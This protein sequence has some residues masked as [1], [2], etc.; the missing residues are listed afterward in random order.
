MSE[1]KY[2]TVARAVTIEQAVSDGL[3]ELGLREHEVNIEVL[4]VPSKGF[5]GLFSQK[6]EVRLT[7][8]DYIMEEEKRAAKRQAEE[9]KEAKKAKERQ[10]QAE[11]VDKVAKRDEKKAKPSREDQPKQKAQTKAPAKEEVGQGKKQVEDKGKKVEKKALTSEREE[12]VSNEGR[13]KRQEGQEEARPGKVV[14]PEDLKIA[15]DQ[16]QKFL[17]Q[18]FAAMDLEIEVQVEEKEGQTFLVLVGDNLGV[19]IGKRGQ[20]LDSLQY[21]LNIAV[22]NYTQ[23]HV[24]LMLD[25]EDYR[26]RRQKT[27]EELADRLA[28][29][30]KKYRKEVSLE[31]MSAYE[32]KVIHAHLQNHT[33]IV[34][35]SYGSEP[36][37]RLVISPKGRNRK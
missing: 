18:V 22:N 26:I 33:G 23:D 15:I 24:R 2:T 29:K 3:A 21:L 9:A 11:K 12:K 35:K 30:A 27:L 28:N 25:A 32:R 20:T 4:T 14:S 16:G 36:Y 19:L 8:L 7:S 10:A 34:T 5:L 6:A 13:A 1:Q 31:P 17:T 37:R